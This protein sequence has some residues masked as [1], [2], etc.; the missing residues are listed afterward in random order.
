MNNLE[1]VLKRLEYLETKVAFQ[2]DTI[3][4][5]NTEIASM[6]NRLEIQRE[7]MKYLV[8]KVKDVQSGQI[9]REEDETP[10]PHY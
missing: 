3:E 9:A 1:D 10:P 6:Q 8:N 4:A 7:Q 5:L 2:D